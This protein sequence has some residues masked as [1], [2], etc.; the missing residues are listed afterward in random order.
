MLLKLWRRLKNKVIG[1]LYYTLQ[2]YEKSQINIQP[3]N[4]FRDVAR[5]NASTKFSEMARIYNNLNDPEKIRIGA[6]C[7]IYGDLLV[8]AHGGRIEIGNFVFIGEQS[9]IWSAVHVSIGNNVM[10][11]HNVNIHDSNSHPLN[12]EL[13]RHQTTIIL[14]KGLPDHA[15]E[16]KEKSIIIEDDVWIGYNASVS[17]GVVIGKGAIVAAG[18][19]VFH[20]VPPYSI[21]MGNPAKIVSKTT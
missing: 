1:K 14:T 2:Y 4:R 13:R 15:F 5:V 16:T 3:E 11:S 7:V 20:D 18:A 17:K 9:K 8:Y 10:I 19:Y 21:V 12:A 6:N